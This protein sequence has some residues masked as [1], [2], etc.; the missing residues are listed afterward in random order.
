MEL[1]LRLVL[2]LSACLILSLI[3]LGRK[4]LFPF[5]I[6]TTWVHECCHAVSA[7]LLGAS[8]IR[9]VVSSDGS[10]LTH[11]KIRPGKIKQALI[12]SSGYLGAS[13]FGCVLFYWVIRSAR[14]PFYLTSDQMVLTLVALISL[15]LLFW[16]R[17]I[18]GFFSLLF[19]AVALASLHYQAL[20]QYQASV[21][22]FLSAQTALNALFDLKTLFSLTS[23][24]STQSDAHTMQKLFMLP[25]WFWAFSWLAISLF[26]MFQ[27]TRALKFYL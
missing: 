7:L 2:I 21:V 25:N 18:F 19:F 6:F 15:S 26:F 3:P 16:V 14:S 22:I 5:Q 8:S 11:Y 23:S 4:L 20:R 27:T 17:N 24:K 9:I 10:G 1:Y 13:A 12:A